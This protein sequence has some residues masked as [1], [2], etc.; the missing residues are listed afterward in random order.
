MAKSNAKAKPTGGEKL[1]NQKKYQSISVFTADQKELTALAIEKKTT[2]AELISAMK[3]RAD[4]DKADLKLLTA[5]AEK[6]N[7]TIG[8]LIKQ[9]INSAQTVAP[10]LTKEYETVIENKEALRDLCA[11]AAAADITVAE[12]LEK[13]SAGSDK[14]SLLLVIKDKEAIAEVIRTGAIMK[15][16]GITE[17]TDD[18]FILTLTKTYK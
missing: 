15:G 17:L 8:K 2:V 11:A 10:F 16:G 7:T 13:L 12:H 9:L 5:T 6:S 1:P 3:E 4:I 14:D 18:K